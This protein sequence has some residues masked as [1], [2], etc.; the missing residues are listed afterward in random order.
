MNSDI[1]KSTSS[2]DWL[3]LAT[4]GSQPAENTGIGL[5]DQRFATML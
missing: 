5:V 3:L 2:V 1:F 4:S